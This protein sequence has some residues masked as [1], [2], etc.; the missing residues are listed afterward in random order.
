MAMTFAL[1]SHL[2]EQLS[3][4]VQARAEKRQKEETEKERLALEVG[5][6]SSDQLSLLTHPQVEEAKTRGTPVTQ[7]SFTAWK[8][9][10]DKEMAG[11]KAREDDEKMRGMTP[12][13]R[14]EYK[15]LGTRL[16]GLS[17]EAYR[18]IVD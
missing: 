18:L 15:K 4:L 14:E 13:E 17:I 6:P 7:E 8:T 12:K 9:Q 11:K 10:F 5:S 2:R 3:V 1:V 16:T